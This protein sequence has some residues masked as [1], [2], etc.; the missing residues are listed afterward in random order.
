M[1]LDH[2]R[3]KVPSNV[4]FSLSSIR[5]D[6]T[7][8]YHGKVDA[9]EKLAAD[10]EQ[11]RMLQAKLCA[12]EHYAVLVIFQA[13]DTAG[14]DGAIKHVMT[15]VN[16]QGVDVHNFKAPSGEEV[17]H[18]YLWRSVK[19]LPQRGHIGIFNRSY[20]E[21]VLVVKVHPELLK[22]EKLPISKVTKD[23]WQQRY[24]DMNNFER[25]LT[26]N[27]IVVLKFFLHISKEEQ[28]KRLLERVEDE[29]KNYKVSMQDI[30][31]RGYWKDYM[32]AY[33]TMLRHT[34]T[35]H[36][37]WYVIPSDHKWFTRVVVADAI[38]AEL[39]KLDPEFPKPTKESRKLLEQVKR[40][41]LNKK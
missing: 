9:V 12:Q 11:L 30:Q 17:L 40:A 15:G 24:E 28:K 6:D 1:P 27:G 34:S 10:V 18:D 5:T 33:E 31:E 13:M 21:E 16:P 32:K 35:D 36:A 41:L 20:Y 25:Y 39:K 2:K 4:S 26:R 23:V 37:P 8:G 7:D 14:K 29:S 38:V 22:N 19:V 3:F